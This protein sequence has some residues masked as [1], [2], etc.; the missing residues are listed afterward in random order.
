LE[1]KTPKGGA[2]VAKK[3]VCYDGALGARVMHE[4]Q[5]YKQEPIYD[6]NAYT[7]ISI[8]YAGN[9]NMY[10]T[11]VTLSGPG[12]SPEYYMSQVGG[13]NTIS[14][15]DIYWRGFTVFWNGRD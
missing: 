5:L 7:I 1:A 6:G 2:D 14:D 10:V 4:L 8:Y 12:G 15:P 11:Y 13:W 3:Q 9:L